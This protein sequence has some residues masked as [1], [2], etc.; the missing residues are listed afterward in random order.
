MTKCYKSREDEPNGHGHYC[1][2]FSLTNDQGK[3]GNSVLL[4]KITNAHMLSPA[5]LFII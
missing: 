3:A 4:V 1:K 2:A 5:F